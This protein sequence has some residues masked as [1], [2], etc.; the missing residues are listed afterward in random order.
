MI[1]VEDFF[2]S[3]DKHNLEDYPDDDTV[4]KVSQFGS[5]MRI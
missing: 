2:F 4:D 3:K 1:T 5:L